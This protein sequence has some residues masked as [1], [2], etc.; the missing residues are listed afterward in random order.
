[1]PKRQ[2]QPKPATAHQPDESNGSST[3]EST[4]ELR[5]DRRF[6]LIQHLVAGA[7]LREACRESGVSFSTGWRI[8]NTDPEFKAELHTACIAAY[9]ETMRSLQ[10]LSVKAVKTLERLLSGRGTSNQLGAAR[11]VLAAAHQVTETLDLM[12]RLEAL[13]RARKN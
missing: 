2:T 9:G 3:S 12:A 1:M 4:R 10:A 7:S 8:V 11:T 5:A 6:Q 13:E